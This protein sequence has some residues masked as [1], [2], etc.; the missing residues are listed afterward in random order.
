M[1]LP[2]YVLMLRQEMPCLA[3]SRSSSLVALPGASNHTRNEEAEALLSWKSK[4]DNQSR[5][6]L[7][8]WNGSNPCSWHGIGYDPFRRIANLNLL[9][10]TI[11]SMFH[12]LNFS[13]LPNLVTIKVANNLLFRNITLSI[14]DLSKL[15]I[16]YFS[17]N[18]LSGNIPPQLRMLQSL[19]L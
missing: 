14:G 8:L 13:Q 19:Q 9:N 18:I 12:H 16:L 6:T 15:I 4:L 7:S 17:Q 5:Y 10:S 2:A 1:L 3:S 11:N